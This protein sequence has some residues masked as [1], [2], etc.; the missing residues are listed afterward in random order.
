[1]D[2]SSRHDPPAADSNGDVRARMAE[3]GRIGGKRRGER[4]RERR[5]AKAAAVLLGTVGEMREFLQRRAGEIEASTEAASLK[6]GAAARI[7]TSLTAL[8]GL[9]EL[10]RENQRLGSENASLRVQLASI[11]ASGASLADSIRAAMLGGQH[12]DETA[13]STGTA[14]V[15]ESEVGP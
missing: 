1:M 10:A 15:D 2:A 13:D 4:E 6:A 9:Q 11:G 12:D 3:L 7:V 14:P 5:A 8:D